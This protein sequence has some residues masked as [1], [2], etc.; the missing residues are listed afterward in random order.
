MLGVFGD[1]LK[2]RKLGYEPDVIYIGLDKIRGF[3]DRVV[4]LLWVPWAVGLREGVVD[5]YDRYYLFAFGNSGCIANPSI[6]RRAIEALERVYELGYRRV[7]L[8]AIRLPSPIDG[9]FFLSTCFC[10]YSLELCPRLSHLRNKIRATLHRASA[11]DIIELLEELA[12]VRAVHVEYL[13][14]IIYDKARELGM[15][16]TAAVFPYPLSKYVGQEP[17]VL[18]RYLREVHVM[19]YHMCPGAACL[20]A[21]IKQL[22]EILT[23][24]GIKYD[25]VQELLRRVTGLELSMGEVKGLDRGLDIRHVEVL[26]EL[27]RHVCGDAYVPIL[28]LDSDSMDILEEFVKRYHR[29]DVFVA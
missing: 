12:Y 27:N 14:S 21:E 20:N 29:L 5:V 18:K 26:A 4:P 25:E 2:V 11:V 16:L 9:L 6:V 13:L 8:D 24:L 7:M 1:V 28:W 19:L 23:A 3:D 10:R 17:K 15:E 22:V